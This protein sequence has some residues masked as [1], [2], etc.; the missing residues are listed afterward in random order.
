MDLG[1]ALDQLVED[2]FAKVTKYLRALALET[3]Y[4]YVESH[5]DQY[6]RLWAEL[7]S[8]DEL[9]IVFR[10]GPRDNYADLLHDDHKGMLRT[11]FVT[12]NQSFM[13]LKRPGFLSG[14][15]GGIAIRIPFG[16]V[17]SL[18]ADT[19]RG[20]LAIRFDRGEACV[21]LLKVARR[22]GVTDGMRAAAGMYH[23]LKSF[24]PEGPRSQLR[25]SITVDSGGRIRL[26]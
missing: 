3:E 4:N 2:Y 8:P 16:D 18:E 26:D 9:S 1:E 15:K 11:S 10:A 7:R 5:L 22:A 24:L 14:P 6:N 21:H 25:D 17:K 20:E 13:F 19:V 12:T 23:F